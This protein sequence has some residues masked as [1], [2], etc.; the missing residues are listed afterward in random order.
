M[1]HAHASYVNR[2]NEQHGATGFFE[3]YQSAASGQPVAYLMHPSGH[4]LEIQLQGAT[5]TRCVCR[6]LCVPCAVCCVCVCVCA[7]CVCCV[8]VCVAC[9]CE[10]CHCWASW[11]ACGTAGRTRCCG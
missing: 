7:V 4:T 2:L 1:H 9:A 11:K 3:F 10:R 6:V 5:I 8:C